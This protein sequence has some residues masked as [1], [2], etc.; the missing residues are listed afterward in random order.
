M[1]RTRRKLPQ[2]R[3]VIR[4][5]TPADIPAIGEV[6]VAGYPKG[7]PPYT[8]GMLRGQI[9][10]FP[11]GQFV[12]QYGEQLVGYCASFRIGDAA[13][14]PHNWHAI[15]GQGF[16]S[17]HDD[18]GEYLYGMEVCVH[19]E[20][21]RLRIGQRFYN[22]RKQLCEEL[23]LKGIVFGGRI[24]RLKRRLHR[25]GSVEAYVSAVQE[26]KLRDPVL[27]FQLRNGF[28]VL[29]ILK[30]Y[31]AEDP[32]SLGYAVHLLW[33]NPA[34]AE[35]LTRD[36]TA[37][38]LPDKV[39]V[40][41]IQY[42]QRRVSSI[43]EFF[44]IVAYFV[45]TVSDYKA[46]FVVFPEL[47]TLQ[48]LSTQDQELPPAAAIEELTRHTELITSTFLE[49][50]LRYNINIIGGSHP[51]HTP[52]GRV[53]NVC[54]VYLRDG[55]VHEQ[56]KI[57]PTPDE[58][59][60]WNIQ[61]GDTLNAIQTDC[62]PIGIQICYDSEFPELSR[63]LADQGVNIIF[64]PFYTDE[65]Q[66]YMRVRHCCHARAVE[67]QCYMVMSG[68]VGNLPNVANM[69]LQYG[70]SCI[71]TPCDFGFARDGVAADTTPNVEAVA[72]ADLDLS[73]LREARSSGT[74]QNLKNRRHDLY[75][76]RWTG[77]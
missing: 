9:N 42:Q 37:T 4:P 71:L 33:R 48:L 75:Q 56:A 77:K 46:D 39:R 64:V 20:Y 60:W 41:T 72:L 58:M 70:Q 25:H 52:R 24:P 2:T 49:F 11:L 44:E 68:N 50:A 16:A 61:G 30:G 29:G 43:Q 36:A 27:S 69:D 66:G 14:K 74:V 12:A 73:A 10:R 13:L 7:T 53:E 17:R 57:H 63:Y 19:P 51:S 3:L 32:D 23:N 59:F 28:E 1:S 62:G 47:F 67:N 6:L 26:G 34:Y 55:S 54:Y 76:V 65:R 22:R 31:T 35:P 8:H 38:H 5:A 45:E 15:T 40:A 18:E 21:R